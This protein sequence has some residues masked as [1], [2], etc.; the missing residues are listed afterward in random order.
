MGLYLFFLVYQIHKTSASGLYHAS[1]ALHQRI[2]IPLLFSVYISKCSERFFSYL[3]ITGQI[4]FIRC[5]S[6]MTEHKPQQWCF[7]D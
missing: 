5:F 7:R 3:G 1:H 2:E 6:I 4:P